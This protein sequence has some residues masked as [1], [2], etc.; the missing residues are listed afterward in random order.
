MRIFGI[1]ALCAALGGC[2]TIT[3]GTTQSILVEVSP[4]TGTCVLSRK[5]ETIGASTPGQRV[6]TVSKESA[7]IR[8]Q[9]SAEGYQPKDDVLSSSLSAATVASFFLLDFGIV[10]AATGAWKK[11]PERITIVLQPL[12]KPIPA[13]SPTS[14]KPTARSASLSEIVNSPSAS[15]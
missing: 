6:V 2:A 5:G 15:K 1:V 13:P 14:K 4:D 8:F 3:E 7:D 11:Y 12:P 10:D 9:C